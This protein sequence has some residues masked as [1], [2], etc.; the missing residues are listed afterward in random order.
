[1]IYRSYSLTDYMRATEPKDPKKLFSFTRPATRILYVEDIY[2]G[3]AGNQNHN[4]WS[5][6]PRMHRLWDPLGIFHSNACTF[7]FMDGHAERKK[8]DDKR[9]VIYCISRTEAAAKGFGKN[10]VFNPP[11]VDLDWL[12]E[13]YPGDTYQGQ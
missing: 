8:W 11:N 2:D 7:S 12:D 13:H 6:E 9:T 10:V 5:Y 4:G 3:S 1:L